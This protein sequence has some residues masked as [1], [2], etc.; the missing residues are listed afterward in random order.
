ME[1]ERIYNAL[2]VNHQK[3]TKKLK[4]LQRQ[5]DRLNQAKQTSDKIKLMKQIIQIKTLQQRIQTGN[6]KLRKEII[7]I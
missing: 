1:L 7:E 3:K 6:A 2:K 4:Q 5:K